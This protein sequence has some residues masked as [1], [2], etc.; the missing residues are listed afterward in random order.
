MKPGTKLVSGP[1]ALDFSVVAR[2][3]VEIAVTMV[4]EILAVRGPDLVGPLPQE[5]QN[6]TDFLYVAAIL[7][8]AKAPEAAKAFIEFISGPTSAPVIKSKGLEP[9]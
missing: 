4:P 1:E 6:A 5:L 7:A 3:E 8:G 9:G 2:G